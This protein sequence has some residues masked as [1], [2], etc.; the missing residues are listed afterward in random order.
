MATTFEPSLATA[1]DRL[2]F[3]LGDTNVGVV[4]PA[5]ADP[6]QLPADDAVYDGVLARRGNDERRATLD[7]AEALIAKYAQLETKAAVEGVESAEWGNRLAAWRE[8]AKRLR[9]E[10]AAEEAAAPGGGSFRVMRPHRPG[11]ARRA[12]YVAD[13]RPPLDRCEW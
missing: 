6:L 11:D 7:L 1:R 9:G 5:G 3:D 4:K 8:L 10:L 12:E 2:R 13:G